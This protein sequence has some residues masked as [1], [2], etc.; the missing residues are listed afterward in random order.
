MYVED[1]FET[2]FVYDSSEL[3]EN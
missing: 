1:I 2:L 3:L